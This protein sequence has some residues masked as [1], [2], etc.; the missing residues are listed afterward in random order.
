MP[1]RALLR[2]TAARV[3]LRDMRARECQRDAARRYARRVPRY[4]LPMPRAPTPH[5]VAAFQRACRHAM[6]GICRCA[7]IRGYS[8][9]FSLLD[10][11]EAPCLRPRYRC[12][13]LSPPAAFSIFFVSA[14]CFSSAAVFALS[15]ARCRCFA[16]FFQRFSMPCR[17]R[18]IYATMVAA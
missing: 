6:I 16:M 5:V 3:M 1:P 12:R 7:A 9:M 18:D 15:R 10:M 14:G 2:R 11:P 4:D 8:F 17:R 13:L